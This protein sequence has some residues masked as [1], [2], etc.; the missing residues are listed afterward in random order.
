MNIAITEGLDLMPP[1]FAD[2]LNVWSSEDGT[3]GSATYDGAANAALVPADQDFGGCL[4]LLKNQSVQKLRWMG[5][6]E[7]RPGVYLRIRAR[8]KA[9]SGVLPDVRIAGFAADASGNNVVALPQVGAATTLTAYGDVVEVSAIVATSNRSGVDMDWG[10]QAAYGHFGLDLTGGSGG[11]VRIDDIVIEDIT[12]AF[13]RDMMDMVDVRDYGARGDGITDD[14][15]AFVAAD[16][17]AAGRTLVVS[18]GTYHIASSLTLQSKVRFDGTLVMDDASRLILIRNFDL[19]TYID[20]F[21]DEVQAFKKG[22]QALINYADHDAFDMKGR[23]VEI[24]GPIDMQAAVADV[25]VF[26]TPRTIRNGQIYAVDSTNWDPD[27]VTATATYNPNDNKTLTGIA[28]AAQ[29]EPGSQVTGAGVGRQVY[30]REVNVAAGS[31]TLSQPLYAPAT[32]QSYTFTRYKYAFDFGGFEVLSEFTLQNIE[33]QMRSKG[34]GVL[35]A[36]SGRAFKLRDCNF[37]R[38]ADRAITSS[39][40]GCQGMQ[41]DRCV[42]SSPDQSLPSVDRTSAALNANANDVKMRDNVFVRF[43]LSALFYGRNHMITGNHMYQGDDIEDAAMAPGLVLTYEAPNVTLSSNYFDNCYIE[44]TNEQDSKPDFGS[45]F[46]F[47]GV[48]ITG[49]I[50]LC[51]AALTSYKFI[52]IKPYGTG[53]SVSNVH[54]NQNLFRATKNNIQRVEGVDTS[55]AD[56]NAWSMKNVT[57]ERNTYVGIEEPTSTPVTLKFQQNTNQTTWTLDP[58]AYLPFDGHAR[59][60][61]AVV[62]EGEIL[63]GSDNRV[64]DMPYVKVNEGP[65][66]KFVQLVWPQACRGT[67]HVTVRADRPV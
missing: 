27:V 42:F 60:V 41:I 6:T 48:T 23:R 3:P 64:K 31:L 36:R 61:T 51:S 46:S 21:G 47:Q 39:G 67:V 62:A 11:I 30:V 35:L 65:D 16:N 54:V 43:G 66:N 1:P 13:L 56:L 58:G 25:D 40:R 34:S 26:Q 22:V 24:D 53:H 57:F 5:Q 12:S 37:N 17:A 8:V 38:P 15:A 18:D 29:I 2:G 63:N 52:V 33:F 4:E 49:N 20:A 50:F 9:V 44:W 19:P 28:N 55:F 7:I 10:T 32:T 14:R 59:T 45:E